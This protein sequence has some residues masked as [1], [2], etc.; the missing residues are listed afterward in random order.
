[1]L[2]ALEARI[3]ALRSRTG[4]EAPRQDGAGSGDADAV[5]AELRVAGVTAGEFARLACVSPEAV[6][7]SG[8]IA[9]PQWAPA[10]VRLVALLTPSA[11]HKLLHGNGRAA[12]HPANGPQSHPFSRIE[13]L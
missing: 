8:A 13:E 7:A 9:P 12:R 1:M 10:A 4:L 5:A 11:R 3:T 6:E 2:D